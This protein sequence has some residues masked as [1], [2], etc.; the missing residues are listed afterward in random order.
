MNKEGIIPKENWTHRWMVPFLKVITSTDK[1]V[2]RFLHVSP[3]HVDIPLMIFDWELFIRQAKIFFK[4]N[5]M[6]CL[7][8][9]SG[10]IGIFHYSKIIE[11]NGTFLTRSDLSYVYTTINR[12]EFRSYTI[13]MTNA[14]S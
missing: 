12:A 9:L 1:S 14:V 11:C 7:M 4:V 8:F 3:V 13:L 5:F 10:G 2:S 6:L